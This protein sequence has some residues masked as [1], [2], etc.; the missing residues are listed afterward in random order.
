MKS[1]FSPFDMLAPAEL[2]APTADVFRSDPVVASLADRA[3]LAV[4]RDFVATTGKPAEEFA[5]SLLVAPDT[6]LDAVRALLAV[7]ILEMLFNE[8]HA[9]ADSSVADSSAVQTDS[10]Q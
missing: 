7:Q 10:V 6:L 5:A 4:V 8:K 3:A 9:P 2:P 1:L